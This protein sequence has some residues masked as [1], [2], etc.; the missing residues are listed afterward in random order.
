MSQVK[1]I[2][3]ISGRSGAGRS[4]AAKALE[5]LGFFVVDNLPPQLLDELLS[6]ANKAPD[7][8]NKVAVTVDVREIPFLE[9]LPK[10]WID[11]DEELYNKSLIYL[12]ASEQKLIGRFQETKRRHPLDDGC[13]IRTALL[14]E[15]DLLVPIRK[16]ATK[17]IRTDQL[18]SHELR[19]LIQSVVVSKQNLN[20]NITLM[21]FGFKHGVP[22]E[23]DL[24]FDVRFLKNPYY[25]PD[26]KA[27]SGLDKEVYDYVLALP[28]AQEF[29]SKVV[30][31]IDFLYPLY[32]QEGK[33]NLTI[34][35]GCT[36]GQHRSVALIEALKN[37]LSQKIDGRVEHRD[38]KAAIL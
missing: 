10:K 31:M 36:G 23:L 19:K 1:E 2:I 15:H 35:I 22:S 18:T 3:I 37:Q 28:H 20:L 6:I 32:V 25:C 29:L 27:K 13:G 16:I 38:L 8:I 7:N 5:D 26:L 9:L 30:N 14:R 34:A 4:T 21:S 24:C 11:I 33:S 12:D 17:E